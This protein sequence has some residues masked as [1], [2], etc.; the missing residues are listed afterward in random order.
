MYRYKITNMTRHLMPAV[1]AVFNT[2]GYKKWEIRYPVQ[3][4]ASTDH[5]A[6]LSQHILHKNVQHLNISLQLSCQHYFSHLKGKVQTTVVYKQLQVI[7]LRQIMKGTLGI[8]GIQQKESEYITENVNAS[9]QSNSCNAE[10]RLIIWKWWFIKRRSWLVGSV[11]SNVKLC[12]LLFY[13]AVCTLSTFIFWTVGLTF[14]NLW[15]FTDWT[16][17][18]E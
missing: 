10:L 12:S 3:Q 18:Q 7:S 13:I 4:E 9:S 8:V 2:L 11:P 14:I 15:Q 5:N 16:D 17:N 1:N 6:M